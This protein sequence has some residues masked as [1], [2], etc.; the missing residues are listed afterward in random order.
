[1]SRFYRRFFIFNFTSKLNDM[2]SKSLSLH[3]MNQIIR[4]IGLFAVISLLCLNSAQAQLN[5]LAAQYF[6]NLYLA[7]PA[8]AGSASGMRFNVASRSQLTALAG[9]PLNTS[10]TL[11]Y[12]INKVGLG[13]NYY[14]DVA[15]LL[16]RSKV[17]VS[18]AYH[19]PLNYNNSKLHFGFS[20]GIQNE[21]L[22]TSAIE[23]SAT[24]PFPFQYNGRA[25]IMNGDFGM[26]FTSEKLSIEASVINLNRQT[27]IE[28]QNSADYSTF[29]AALS[30]VMESREWQYRPKLVYRGVRNY[31]DLFDIGLQVKPLNRQLAFMGVYHSY[32]SFSLGLNYQVSR[33]VELMGVYNTATTAIRNYANGAFEIGLHFDFNKPEYY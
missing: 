23:G 30:Y 2:L 1:M 25:M 27:M 8:L 15:G 18:Y 20:F 5:P 3:Q 24:D 21:N 11:D 32:R 28:N 14:Q 17:L 10:F 22:N 16:S 19:I 7:S 13:L 29:Y 9:K 12:G 31:K 33:S 4:G 26:A 6:Q